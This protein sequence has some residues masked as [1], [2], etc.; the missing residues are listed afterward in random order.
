MNSAMVPEITK[1]FAHRLSW[2]F[3][4]CK[5]ANAIFLKKTPGTN[6][7]GTTKVTVT[8]EFGEELD[9]EFSRPLGISNVMTDVNCSIKV[10]EGSLIIIKNI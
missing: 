2:A 1:I 9:I 10:K 5:I 8:S 3:T 7:Y 4:L 6:T